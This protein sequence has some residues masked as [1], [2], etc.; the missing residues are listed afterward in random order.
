MCG[1]RNIE[2][3]MWEIETINIGWKTTARKGDVL[4]V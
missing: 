2:K 4:E 1:K 3:L